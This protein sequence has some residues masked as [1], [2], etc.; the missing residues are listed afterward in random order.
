MIN[1]H[2]SATFPTISWQGMYEQ[3]VKVW[4]SRLSVLCDI[5]QDIRKSYLVLDIG[6]HPDN[7]TGGSDGLLDQWLSFDYLSSKEELYAFRIF[8]RYPPS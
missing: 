2:D 1:G 4:T 7:F 3:Y 6:Y 5:C 8:H